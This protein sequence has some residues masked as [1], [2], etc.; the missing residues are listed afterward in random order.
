MS[1]GYYSLGRMQ[2]PIWTFLRLVWGEWS[3]RVTGSLSAVLVLL[4]FGISIAGITGSKIPHDSTIQLATWILAAVC[5]GQAAYAT[6]ARERNA[7]QAAEDAFSRI[8]TL[9]IA[10]TGITQY[11]GDRAQIVELEAKNESIEELLNCI[12][13]VTEIFRDGKMIEARELPM[14]L[15]CV[16]RGPGGPFDLKPGQSKRIPICSMRDNKEPEIR[17][18]TEKNTFTI[19]GLRGGVCE[20]TV[21][22]YGAK[23]P[24]IRKVIMSVSAEGELQSRLA[25]Q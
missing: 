11:Q 3:S 25:A 21:E 1:R 13:M 2:H 12:A 15:R 16:L 5:G 18:W 19:R 24:A 4:G 10:I 7:R 9:G 20:L 23:K 8:T 17:I 22:I 14:P 6:W